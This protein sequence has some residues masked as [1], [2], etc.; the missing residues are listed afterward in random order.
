[1]KFTKTPF[2]TRFTEQGQIYT[3]YRT[4]EK[5]FCRPYFGPGGE[6]EPNIDGL[7]A[8]VTCQWRLRYEDGTVAV[9][10]DDRQKTTNYAPYY[11]RVGGFTGR[12]LELVQNTI[13]EHAEQQTNK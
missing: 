2:T 12:S 9:V 8:R 11:W 1:M 5:I 6:A 10:Y 3:T 4:L 13:K 7:L